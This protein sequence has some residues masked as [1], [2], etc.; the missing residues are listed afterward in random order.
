[1]AGVGVAREGALVLRDCER[2]D[3]FL[4]S[5]LNLNVGLWRMKLNF[6]SF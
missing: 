3:G 4:D 2:F 6:C 5:V 1:M